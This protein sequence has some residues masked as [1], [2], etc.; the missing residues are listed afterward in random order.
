VVTDPLVRQQPPRLEQTVER[1]QI[2]IEELQQLVRTLV[3]VLSC[4]CLLLSDCP[5]LFC[6][7]G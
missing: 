4:F 2:Q 1:Q 6:L 5:V 7:T 3:S